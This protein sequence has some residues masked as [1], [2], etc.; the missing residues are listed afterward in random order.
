LREIHDNPQLN[1]TV[2]GFLDDAPGK[3]GRKIHGVSVRGIIG[4]IAFVAEKTGAEE[5]LI[6]IP[7]ASAGEMRRIASLCKKSGLRFKTATSSA[8]KRSNSMR[9]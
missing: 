5:I 4:D 9:I 6:A 3:I 2:V 7:S 1:Y 8:V